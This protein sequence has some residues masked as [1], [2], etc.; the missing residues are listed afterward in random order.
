MYDNG[1]MICGTYSLNTCLG[2]QCSVVL[3]DCTQI[4]ASMSE[5]IYESCLRCISYISC[6]LL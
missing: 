4:L 1:V 2:I 3:L 5:L 6:E